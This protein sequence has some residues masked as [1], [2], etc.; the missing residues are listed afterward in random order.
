MTTEILAPA[1]ATTGDR[2][3]ISIV[4]CT[5]ERSGREERLAEVIRKLQAQTNVDLEIVLVWQGFD[6]ALFPRYDG[7]TT[8]IT[9]LCSSAESRNI[10][11]DHT[12]H[13][14]IAFYD[15]D[16]YPIEPDQLWRTAKMMQERGLDFIASNIRSEGDVQSAAP[17]TQDVIYD[18]NNMLN[19]L[20]EPGLMVKREAFAATRFDS[21]LGIGCIHG[22]SE[23][24]DFG[25]RLLKAGYKGQRVATLFIDHPPLDSNVDVN[26]ERYFFYSL[27]NGSALLQ[28]G[29]RYVYARAIFRASAR[30]VVSLLTGNTP[31]A[32]AAFV[33]VLCLMA[34][35]F[36]PRRNARL[37]PR[38]HIKAPAYV[39][40]PVAE[41]A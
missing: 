28:H 31:R 21:T 11:A 9:D 1:Q 34:G 17:I 10:G 19:N 29:Y 15:D 13:G 8:V 18:F 24:M 4:I 20:W 32:K 12:R 25:Y 27:G 30:V 39:L 7:V 26:I 22:S 14:L 36:L 3:A 37:L 38:N 41:Q 33:R 35:P 5:I 2:V 23:G 16:V 40:P 6:P